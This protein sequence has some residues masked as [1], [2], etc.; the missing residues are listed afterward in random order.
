MKGFMKVVF[1]SS[2]LLT[3]LAVGAIA[4]FPVRTVELA[5][6]TI[7]FNHP[8]ALVNAETTRSSAGATRVFYYFTLE[9][10][11]DA[12]EP[13]QRLAITQE[14]GSSFLRRVEY[15]LEDTRTFMGTV[16]DRGSE[17][18]IADAVYNQDSQT[19]LITLANPV[20]PGSTITLAL[21][22]N[23]NPRREGVYLFG[24]TAFPAGEQTQ[25]QFLGYGRFHIYRSDSPFLINHIFD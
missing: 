10:P 16:G 1:F 17:V 22:P 23:R 25:G 21:R 11:G 13:L 24:V 8:P 14:D 4:P 15:D 19:I 18:A 12:G 6:G 20:P 5:D 7:A 2:A 9:L 3:S